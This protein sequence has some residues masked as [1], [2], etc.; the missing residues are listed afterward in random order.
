M[1]RTAKGEDVM[2]PTPPP[3]EA[4]RQAA[5]MHDHN[6]LLD[7][8]TAGVKIMRGHA[9]TDEQK[10]RLDL[11]EMQIVSLR[12]D[13]NHRHIPGDIVVAAIGLGICYERMVA[14]L[15]YEEDVVR[16]KDVKAGSDA[17][18]LARQEQGKRADF[19][20]NVESRIQKRGSRKQP[21]DTAIVTRAAKE[22]KLGMRQAWRY[23]GD[24]NAQKK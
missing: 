15:G 16:G 1:K 23:W 10:Y 9:E 8:L 20:R 7:E 22:C 5:L 21:S 12:E 4:R 13:V 3:D 11:T 19:F 14:E 6:M 2:F 24:Y 18:A 17:G